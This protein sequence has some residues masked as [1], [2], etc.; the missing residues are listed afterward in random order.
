MPVSET[1]KWSLIPDPAMD[2]LCTRISTLPAGVNFTAFE[3][4]FIKTWRSRWS[5]PIKRSGRSGWTEYRKL[6]P[7][8]DARTATGLS[9]SARA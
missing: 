2:S 7:F 4:R 6:R 5:S 1:V 9:T 8:P 3:A